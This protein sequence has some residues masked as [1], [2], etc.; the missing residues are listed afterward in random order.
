MTRT[1]KWANYHNEIVKYRGK[2]F[3]GQ[4]SYMKIYSISVVGVELN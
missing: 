3:N 1:A 2:Y 4:P